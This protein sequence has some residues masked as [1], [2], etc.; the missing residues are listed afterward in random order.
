VKLAAT[1]ADHAK[2]YALP[3]WMLGV[4]DFP[5]CAFASVEMTVRTSGRRRRAF[6][7]PGVRND[8]GHA[9]QQS[10]DHQ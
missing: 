7:S 6:W 1:D 10:R 4:M 5:V 2:I 3:N 9:A 8:T